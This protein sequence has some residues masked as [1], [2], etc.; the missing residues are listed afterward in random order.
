MIF[1][2]RLFEKRIW[3]IIFKQRLTEPLHLNIFSFFV[4]LFGSFRK[5]VAFDLV[6]R[7]YHAFSILQ[8]ADNAKSMGLKKITVI[9]FGVA[10]GTGLMNMIEISK[11]VTKIT[12]IEILIYGFDTGEGMPA[13]INFKDHPEYYNTGDFPMNKELLLEKTK[14]KATIIFGNIKESLIEFQKQLT[15]EAPIGYIS[16]DVDYYSSTKDVFKLLTCN[17]SNFLPLTYIYFDDISLPHHNTKCGELLAINEFNRD[18]D[19]RNIEY[20]SFFVNERIFKNTNWIKQI[21]YLHILDH[22]SRFN[23]NVNRGIN[24]LDNPYLKFDGNNKKFN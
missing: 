2:R 21:Y 17:P 5:K 15:F 19:L 13:P 9:E 23:I 8:A 18:N 14:N 22:E 12:G 20:H 6:L 24:I 11:K 1:L 16:I 10:N 3:N 4:L 7:P